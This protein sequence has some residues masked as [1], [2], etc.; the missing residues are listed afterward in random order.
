VIVSVFQ[1]ETY[2][3]NLCNLLSAAIFCFQPIGNKKPLAVDEVID[4]FLG[5]EDAPV[6]QAALTK[7]D[8]QPKRAGGYR[9][10][11]DDLGQV[12]VIYPS[13]RLDFDNHRSVDH[14]IGI[15]VSNQAFLFIQHFIVLL[16]FKRNIGVR[17]LIRQRLRL[18][19]FPQSRPKLPVYRH[20]TTNDPIGHRIIRS[21]KKLIFHACGRS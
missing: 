12:A 15:V 20:C 13:Q 3:Q 9:Q 8:Q 7:V 21:C 10:I 11:T 14:K 17:Q 19:I 1:F 16:L 5:W 18:A 6:A 4:Y 2:S